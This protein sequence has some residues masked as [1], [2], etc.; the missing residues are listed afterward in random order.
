MCP[1][2]AR[3]QPNCSNPLAD[4]SSVLLCRDRQVTSSAAAKQKLA[5]LL[6]GGSDII[7]DR[8]SGLLRHFE[9]DRLAGLP[10]AH[11]CAID[12]VT[13]RSNVLGRVPDDHRIR[14]GG[15]R[16]ARE[17]ATRLARP[18]FHQKK[19]ADDRLVSSLTRKICVVK[20][21]MGKQ[22]S[23]GDLCPRVPDD[24]TRSG[25]VRLCSRAR[26]SARSHALSSKMEQDPG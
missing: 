14:S 16:C 22:P 17:L 15:V 21:G 2:E 13:M 11:R 12:R 3:V 5:R 9:P 6:I 20:S 8:L 18:F 24:H 10:L 23:R 1:K 26:N 19:T 25:S 4:Q 7:V